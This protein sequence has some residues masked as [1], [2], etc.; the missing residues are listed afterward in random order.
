MTERVYWGH[1]REQRIVMHPAELSLFAINGFQAMQKHEEL[2]TLIHHVTQKE[3]AVIVEIGVGKGGTSWVWSK[4][5]SV[6]NIIA[7][8]MPNGPWG[9]GPSEESIQ[10]IKDNCHCAYNFISGDSQGEREFL[11]VRSLLNIP[12]YPN[13]NKIDFLFI[14]GDHSYEGV[15]KDY[16]KYSPLV[17]EGG[18]IAFH[19]ICEH[20]P[21]SGC[22]VKKFWDELTA[23]LSVYSQEYQ[24]YHN[25]ISEPTIWGGIGLLEK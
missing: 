24:R 12:E 18:L 6:R 22:E 16:L 9:G 5:P 1:A 11:S 13:L 7:I 20:A 17:R 4:L 8:D 3:P 23:P 19:D 15:K 25:I 14:D 10:Y 21:E 2:R